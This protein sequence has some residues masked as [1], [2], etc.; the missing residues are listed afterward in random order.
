MDAIM[1]AMRWFL[2]KELDRTIDIQGDS[3]ERVER[4]LESHPEESNELC[5]A[6]VDKEKYITELVTMRQDMWKER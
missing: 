4:H 2:T 3:I 5:P 1:I 6:I